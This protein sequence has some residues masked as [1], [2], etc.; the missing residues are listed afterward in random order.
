[1][2]FSIQM[3]GTG[4]TITEFYGIPNL[5]DTF[6]F[7]EGGLPLAEGTHTGTNTLITNNFGSFVDSDTSSIFFF[8]LQGNVQI[9]YVVN[10]VTISSDI[11]PSGL[12]ELRGPI[13]Q[14]EDVIELTIISR[15]PPPPPVQTYYEYTVTS[16]ATAEEACSASTTFTVYSY[17]FDADACSGDLNNWACYPL[18]SE[19]MFLDSELTIECG[20][21]F[22]A[23]EYQT[24]VKGV[25]EFAG[26]MSNFTICE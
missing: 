8:A 7:E 18:G 25:Y 24:G 12:I 22:Y 20:N 26:A 10:S 6:T 16:G 13:I 11:Y 9:A 4:T 14:P 19:S 2:P 15:Y 17:S 21:G 23:S 3:I 5:N 1:M